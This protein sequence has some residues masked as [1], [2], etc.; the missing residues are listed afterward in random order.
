MLNVIKNYSEQKTSFSVYDKPRTKLPT[1][2]FCLFNN[3]FGGKFKKYAYGLDFVIEYNFEINSVSLLKRS[4][5]T[6]KLRGFLQE[7][8]NFKERFYHEIVNLKTL[9]TAASTPCYRLSA[10]TKIIARSRRRK[11]KVY[12]N[13]TIDLPS[14][15][16][17]ITSEENALGLPIWQFRDGQMETV[18]IEK[19]EHVKTFIKPIEHKFLS[20][21][22]ECRK[23]SFIECFENYFEVELNKSSCTKKCAPLTMPSFPLCVTKMEKWCALRA[24]SNL[25]ENLTDPTSDLCHQPCKTL[26][27]NVYIEKRLKF[28][29]SLSKAAFTFSYRFSAPEL[30]TVY[31]EY[32]IYDTISMVAYTGGILGMCI[33]FSFMNAITNVINFF[34]NTIR[35]IKFKFTKHNLRPVRGIM[36]EL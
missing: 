13:T 21:K 22:S 33:G 7:G 17:Y 4:N 19:F 26:Q 25:I 2:T 6:K 18:N 31:Q 30:V 29:P 1:L 14:L 10:I 15:M 34:Q 16:I 35:I 5:D 23:E 12:F 20:K 28:L 27:Y 11:I 3:F 9:T 8:D 32:L 36:K 24:G